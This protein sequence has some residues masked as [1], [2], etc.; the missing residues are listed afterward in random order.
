MPA[1]SV[2]TTEDMMGK[3]IPDTH[4]LGHLPTD[5]ASHLKTSCT[6]PRSMELSRLSRDLIANSN[7]SS[8]LKF[9]NFRAA[10]SEAMKDHV[11]YIFVCI[12]PF[13]S[14]NFGFDPLTHIKFI[15]I[16]CVKWAEELRSS[17]F[18][19]MCIS[20]PNTIFWTFFCH[21]F[22][23]LWFS[24]AQGLSFKMFLIHSADF[25][26]YPCTNSTVLNY[27]ILGTTCWLG[28][29]GIG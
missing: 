11:T 16:T 4:L 24:Y 8:Q 22:E 20:F 7:Q 17:L 27:L 5:W 18:F 9:S 25:F 26:A 3:E 1:S 28:S 19:Y 29:Q 15:V 13:L 14:L 2:V 21:P 23:M 10:C 6:F 12:E